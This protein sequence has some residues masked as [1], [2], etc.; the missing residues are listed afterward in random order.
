MWVE[1]HCGLLLHGYFSEHARW[2]KSCAVNGYPSRQGGTI[3]PTDD[4]P[5]CPAN[6][7][8]FFS[9]GCPILIINLLLT[10][11]DQLRWLDISLLPFLHLYWPWFCLCSINMQKNRMICNVRWSHSWSI[12]HIQCVYMRVLTD[13]WYIPF[14]T[15][16]QRTKERKRTGEER[17]RWK[18]KYTGTQSI[19]LYTTT[20]TYCMCPFNM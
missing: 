18:R 17:K 14:V 19:L 10:K 2:T 1:G 8:Q 7:D 15:E 6:N 12:T 13:N 20:C 9:F 3:L 16:K 4:Y 11:L 5:L